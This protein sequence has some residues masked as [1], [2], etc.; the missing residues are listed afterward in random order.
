MSS[1]E[2]PE[3][4]ETYP[5]TNGS[6]QG[7]RKEINPATKAVYKVISEDM[8]CSE[9]EPSFPAVKAAEISLKPEQG[10]LYKTPGTPRVTFN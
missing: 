5:G 4:K 2:T 10:Y 7:D 8:V 9:Y 1:M 3:I 6:T